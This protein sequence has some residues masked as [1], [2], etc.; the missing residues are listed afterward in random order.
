V[1]GFLVQAEYADKEA[2]IRLL[3]TAVQNGENPEIR[4]LHIQNVRQFMASRD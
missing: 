3:Q 1:V 2:V 4:H